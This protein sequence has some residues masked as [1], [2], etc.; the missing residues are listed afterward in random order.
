MKTSE[1]NQLFGPIFTIGSLQVAEMIK[2]AGFD[3]VMIDMEHSAMSLETVHSC[4]QV[5]GSEILR[6]VR[7]PGNDVNWIKRVLDTGCDGM[8]VPM[9]KTREEA[10]IAVRAARYPPVGQ[11]SVGL[12]RAHAYGLRSNEYLASANRELIIMLQIEHIDAVRNIDEILAVKGIDSIFIGPYDLSAS[13]DLL[14]QVTHPEVLKTID[15]I[16]NKCRDAGIP[17]GIFGATPEVLVRELNDGCKYML[18]GV[19]LSLISSMLN[20]LSGKLHRMIQ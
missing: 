19:D 8:M 11:R 3:W 18:C 12:T 17:Y 1:R 2:L 9:I 15:F 4:L 6:I 13:M 20:D 16:K 14:G 5:F 10:L 7:V